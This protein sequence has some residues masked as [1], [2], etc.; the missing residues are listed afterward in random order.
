MSDS[1]I[2][3]DKFV[4]FSFKLWNSSQECS[5]ID[6]L[7]KIIVNVTNS[8]RNQWDITEIAMQKSADSMINEFD[9]N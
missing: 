4:K 7:S 2:E 5:I 1:I 9:S 6:I 3:E 8:H